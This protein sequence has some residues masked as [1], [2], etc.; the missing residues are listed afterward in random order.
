M[1]SRL[2]ELD[3]FRGFAAISVML[4]HF[5]NRFDEMYGHTGY[6]PNLSLGY[7][8]L[9]L[10]FLLSGFVTVL[11]LEKIKTPTDFIVSRFSRLFPT[12]WA[13][14]TITFLVLI[15]FP[16]P[17]NEIGGFEYFVNL[18]MLQGFVNVP[19]VDGAHWTLM[20]EL[21]FYFIMFMIFLLGFIFNK[22]E[23]IIGTL[24]LYSAIS[25]I[26]DSYFEISII[27]NY[28]YTLLNFGYIQ[29]L[30]MGMMF[31]RIHKYGPTFERYG[32]IL[33]SLLTHF[34]Y[35]GTYEVTVVSVLCLMFIIFNKGYLKFICV[36]PLLFLGNISYALFLIHQNIGYV[37]IR[38]LE[39]KGLSSLLSISIAILVSISLAIILH[40]SIEKPGLSLIRKWHR[41]LKDY[42]Q[43][44]MHESRANVNITY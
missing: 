17:N 41:L 23:L 13:S 34:L 24:I 12:Y 9:H 5:T 28:L 26:S 37:L 1:N 8:R 4:Y 19:Y 27:H 2:L 3:V 43:S 42:K 30:A 15:L 35:H 32:I 36:A 6:F 33:L 31:Y 11:L 38:N 20:L 10:F 14:I 18:T 39:S 25:V 22:L 7:Y 40:Y 29:V 44:K 16:L 21:K